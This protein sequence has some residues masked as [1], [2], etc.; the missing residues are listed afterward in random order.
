LILGYKGQGSGLK[1]CRSTAA[2]IY[3]YGESTF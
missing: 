3:I 1:L 2:R